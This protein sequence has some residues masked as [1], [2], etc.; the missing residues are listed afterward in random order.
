M[1]QNPGSKSEVN[2]SQ[3]APA[4]P[5]GAERRTAPRVALALEVSFGTSRDAVR[6]CSRDLST[7]GISLR[8]SARLPVGTPLQMTVHIPGFAVPLELEA[9]VAWSRPDAMGLAFRN[10][11]SDAARRLRELIDSH[12]SM[13]E[14]VLGALGR[15]TPSQPAPARLQPRDGGVRLSLRDP[16]TSD[17]LAELLRDCG[18][19]V[20]DDRIAAG[21]PDLV[22]TVPERLAETARRHPGVPLVLLGVS[23]P[24]A[25]VGAHVWVP[26]AR[27]VPRHAQPS[28]VLEAVRSVLGASPVRAA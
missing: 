10:L 22:V 23:G 28:T 16:L 9:E 13:K 21:R 24:D 18:M 26:V 3:P 17:V 5:V 19:R 7:G 6:A 8:T 14:R 27:Y 1:Q 2:V 15:H 12:S 25:L 11:T 4:R 20:L